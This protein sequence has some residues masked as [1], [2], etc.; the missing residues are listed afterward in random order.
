MIDINFKRRLKWLSLALA[1]CLSS[2]SGSPT[3]SSRVDGGY[4]GSATSGV[5][6]AG[7]GGLVSDGGSVANGGIA[8]TSVPD[9]SSGGSKAIGAGDSGADTLS[10]LHTSGKNIVDSSGNKVLL[11]GVNLGGWLVTEKWMCPLDSGSLPDT[12]SVVQTL[13]TRFGIA[14]EQDLVATYQRTWITVDDL[15]NIKTGGYNVVRVP[16]WWGNFYPINNISNAGW[17]SDAFA[18]LDWLVTQASTRGL[19]VI[20]DMHGAVGGQSTADHTGQQNSN[21]YWSDSNN[22]GNT[23]WM[24]WQIANHFAGN[25][26]VAGYDLLNEPTGAPSTNDV[27]NAYANL[28]DSVRSADPDHIIIVE[29]AFGN[30]NWDMLP[31]PSVPNWTNVVYEMHEYQ[32]NGTAAQIKAGAD[33]QV[34]DFN[35]HSAWNVPGYIGE[36]NDF[37]SGADT[38]RYSIDAY[39]SAGLSWTMWSYKAATG[40]SPTAWGWYYPVGSPRVPDIQNDSADAIAAAWQQWRTPAAFII[41]SAI[42]M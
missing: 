20:I 7:R 34:N 18:M 22:Q 35:N 15:D 3:A 27:W 39:K 37:D 10:M 21:Q 2:C 33:N 6:N 36:F 19:Y 30:W 4:S 26:A 16:V 32:W 28:Y 23:A 1:Q 17:R 14:T 24:W 38:W 12:Y 8:N 25:P 40:T 13:D 29:G 31:A 42:G 9:T 11:R 41:N 5:S